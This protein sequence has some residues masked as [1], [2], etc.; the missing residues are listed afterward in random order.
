MMSDKY[1]LDRAACDAF[2]ERSHKLAAAAIEA[3]CAE[4]AL[5]VQRVSCDGDFDDQMSSLLVAVSSD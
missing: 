5:R 1:G 2:A 4:S 3:A